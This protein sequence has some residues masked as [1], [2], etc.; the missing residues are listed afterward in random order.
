[1]TAVFIEIANMT[2]QCSV[3]GLF[4]LFYVDQHDQ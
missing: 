4:F 1:L 2:E 3:V